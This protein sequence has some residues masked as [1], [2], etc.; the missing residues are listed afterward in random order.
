[1]PNGR[2][3]ENEDWTALRAVL[4]RLYDDKPLGGDD[5]RDLADRMRLIL[6]RSIEV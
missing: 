2:A 6:D 1:M 3:L 4:A 5:R